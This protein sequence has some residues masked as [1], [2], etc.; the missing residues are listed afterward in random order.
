MFHICKLVCVHKMQLCQYKYLI[1]THCINNAT[2]TTGIHTLQITGICPR[3][4]IPATLQIYV[5]LYYYRSLRTDFI[6]KFKKLQ[7]LIT[8][9]LHYM[10]QQICPSHAIY[11]LHAQITPFALKGGS[12]PIYIWNN[13]THWHQSCNEEC[14]TQK[15]LMQPLIVMMT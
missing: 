2:M 4:N 9:P 5:S 1:W 11:I 14:C 3:T 13:W 7:L 12:L 8:K 6:Y 10:C 15:T